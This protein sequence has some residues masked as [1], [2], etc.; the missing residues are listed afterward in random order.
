AAPRD[1]RP[2][3]RLGAWLLLSIAEILLTGKPKNFSQKVGYLFS[4][5]RGGFR[6]AARALV[7]ELV[8]LA[9]D[10]DIFAT[11][12]TL[13]ILSWLEVTYVNFTFLLFAHITFLSCVFGF[14]LC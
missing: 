14:G 5:P 7:K 9:K 3:A 1:W 11:A 4:R 10:T 12:A 8:P 2:L 13:G 6:T